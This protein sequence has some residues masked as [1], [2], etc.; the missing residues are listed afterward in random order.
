LRRGFTLIELL[1]VIAII[2]ILAAILFPVFTAVK[3]SA[4][5]TACLSN[6]HQVGMATEM[7]MQDYDFTYP[8]TKGTTTSKP[9]VDDMDGSIEEPDIG[10]MF[11]MILPYTGVRSDYTDDD[12]IRQKLYVCPSDTNPNDPTCPTVILPGG[13]TV[14]SYLVNGYFVWGIAES[15]V[16]DFSGTIYVGERRSEVV[17]NTPQYCDDIWHPW[18]NANT[19]SQGAP[20]D[21]MDPLIGAIS[22]RH[23][24]GS[25]FT[26]ADGHSAWKRLNQTF[27][28]DGKIDLH[29]PFVS[30]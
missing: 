23:K 3:E 21:D 5:K 17:N 4:K 30:H 28:L 19:I 14:N 27:S 12:M 29:N 9:Q 26:F 22:S 24:G 18:W 10:S 7:Y 2:A 25:N 8:Q 11:T 16:Q 13:P 1:V 20:E 6:L 15:Q